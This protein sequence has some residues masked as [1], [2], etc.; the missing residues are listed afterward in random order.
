MP[1]KSTPARDPIHQQQQPKT[2][3][4][5]RFLRRTKHDTN[6]RTAPKRMQNTQ[7]KTERLAAFLS[8]SRECPGRARTQSWQR[9]SS[10]LTPKLQRFCCSPPHNFY[11]RLVLGFGRSSACQKDLWEDRNRIFHNI[12]ICNNCM[13]LIKNV[14]SIS[15]L[16]SV[17]NTSEK[18][19]K[20]GAPRCPSVY[21]TE[22][23][24]TGPV[25][26]SRE[27]S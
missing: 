15:N 8:R 22:P 1:S 12:Y 21:D 16:I 2:T 25:P 4:Q 14:K 27:K 7:D 5:P 23:P 18:C 17:R 19:A 13:I 6:Q 24:D 26:F 20:N 10:E 3:N 9:K 11:L